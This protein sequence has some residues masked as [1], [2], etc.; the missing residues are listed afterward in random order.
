[1]DIRLL[2]FQRL[3]LDRDETYHINASNTNSQS[4]QV[5]ILVRININKASSGAGIAQKYGRHR[6]KRRQ[7]KRKGRKEKDSCGK[8]KKIEDGWVKKLRKEPIINTK[9]IH[10]SLKFLKA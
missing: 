8:G 7:G 6:P 4:T 2:D 5:I 9:G 10:A 1:M 3:S